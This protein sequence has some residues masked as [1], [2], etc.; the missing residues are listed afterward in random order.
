MTATRVKTFFAASFFPEVKLILVS[1]QCHLTSCDQTTVNWEEAT[2]NG[3]N[4]GSDE[5]YNFVF[6]GEYI[7]FCTL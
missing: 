5:A 7:S 6:K 3:Q 1:A 4:M 2:L